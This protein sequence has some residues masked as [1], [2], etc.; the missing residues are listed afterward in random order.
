[1]ALSSA[2]V[3]KV[4]VISTILNHRKNN[5]RK[6]SDAPPIPTIPGILIGAKEVQKLARKTSFVSDRTLCPRE[7]ILNALHW[8][9]HNIPNHFVDMNVLHWLVATGKVLKKNDSKD[10]LKFTEAV[11]RTAKLVSDA[12]DPCF[13]YIERGR[14]CPITDGTLVAMLVSIRAA[15]RTKSHS[16]WVARY[17]RALGDPEKLKVTNENREFLE[18]AIKNLPYLNRIVSQ[19]SH[20]LLPTA[21]ST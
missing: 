2:A 10:I 8:M 11:R 4:D 18:P 7:R 3:P 9:I 21:K 6:A 14:V 16:A 20:L 13:L 19:G 12:F 5:R 1:M 15:K 17:V